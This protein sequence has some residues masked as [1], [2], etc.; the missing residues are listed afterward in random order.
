MTEPPE[1]RPRR[2]GGYCDA[3]FEF[4]HDSLRLAHDRAG[5]EGHVRGAE[6]LDAFRDLARREFGPLARTVLASWGVHRTDDV[7][8]IV[9]RCVEAGEMGRTD[10]D[11]PDDFRAVYEF[12]DA[13]PEDP[14]PV[15]IA[16]RAPDPDED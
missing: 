1:R 7:G 4:V 16:R 2:L 3:A 15:E 14:G 12:D 9:F 10:D 13:F 6:L 5:R 11:S 8:E